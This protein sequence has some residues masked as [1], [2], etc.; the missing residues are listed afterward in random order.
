VA[1]WAA[2]GAKVIQQ[3]VAL[4]PAE[5]QVAVEAGRRNASQFESDAALDEIEAIYRQLVP[6]RA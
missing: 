6:A 1:A 2:A 5:R 3:V 4:S